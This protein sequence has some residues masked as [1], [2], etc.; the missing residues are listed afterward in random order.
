MFT[1][2]RFFA[3]ALVVVGL[4]APAAAQ[5]SPYYNHLKCYQIKGQPVQKVIVADN[6]FGRER[7]VKLVPYLLCAPTHK[8]C[9]SNPP[10]T[11]GCQ[12]VPCDSDKSQ[13][14]PAPVD[15]FKCYKIGLKPCTDAAGAPVD[16]TTL[17]TF[18]KN[19]IKVDLADQFD[20]ETT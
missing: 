18:A 16:C 1:R 12:P 3:T 13:F 9:C 11:K 20:D 19:A 4:A 2:S 7:I 5:F 6:Q 17:A 14:Q 8:T 15:H 10:T